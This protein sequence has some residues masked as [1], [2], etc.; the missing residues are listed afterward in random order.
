MKMLLLIL[1]LVL[2]GCSLPM[3]QEK[4]LDVTYDMRENIVVNVY[5][6]CVEYNYEGN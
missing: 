4:P 3:L 2:T 5:R 6:E 1:C